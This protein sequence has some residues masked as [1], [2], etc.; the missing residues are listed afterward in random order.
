MKHILLATIALLLC[1]PAAQAVPLGEN[2]YISLPPETIQCVDIWLPDAAGLFTPGL[3]PYELLTDSNWGDLTEQTVNTDENNTVKVPLCFSSYGRSEGQCSN[4]YTLSISTPGLSKYFG[5]GVCISKFPDVEYAK[6]KPGEGPQEVLNNNADIFAMA[7]RNPSVTIK[8]GETAAFQLLIESYASVTLDLVS[9]GLSPAKKTVSLSPSNPK[10]SLEFT[11]SKEGDVSVTATIR[12]CKGSSCSHSASGKATPPGASFT[13]FSASIFPLTLNIKNLDPV[14]Y[15][16][17][18]NNFG[19]KADF[20]VQLF[21]PEGMEN[22]FKKQSFSVEGKKTIEFQVTP[23]N[24]STMYEFFALVTSGDDSK[25][26]SATLSTNELLTDA[27]RRAEAAKSSNPNAAEEID[28]ELD[29]WYKKYKQTAYGEE[30]GEYAE[31]QRSID[32]LAVPENVPKQ[33]NTTPPPLPQPQP[34]PEQDYTLILVAVIA[35]AIILVA[36]FYFKKPRKKEID[37]PELER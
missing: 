31:L 34:E 26:A 24:T 10:T 12:N 33:N 35:A 19:D 18:I 13:G 9:E 30:L 8:S 20:E 4:T 1:I 3:R 22:N 16:L 7:F 14:N 23:K 5:G 6:P 37:V 2:L 15:E 21:T 27:L 32:K 36:V 17:T 28:A 29:S 25:E 11:A